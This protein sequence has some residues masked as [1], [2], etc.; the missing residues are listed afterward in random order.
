MPNWCDNW[1]HVSGEKNEIDRFV[2]AGVAETQRDGECVSIG[3]T[4]SDPEYW[5]ENDVKID[6]TDDEAF[7]RFR[8]EHKVRLVNPYEPQMYL[9][10]DPDD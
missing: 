7:N 6:D 10:C 5:D 4:D 2:E 9:D 8:R 3:I 1:L